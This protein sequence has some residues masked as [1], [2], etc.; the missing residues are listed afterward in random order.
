[1]ASAG[2]SAQAGGSP[3]KLAKSA[4]GGCAQPEAA[5]IGAGKS[6]GSDAVDNCAQARSALD[7]ANAA[8]GHAFSV[9]AMKIPA[10]T[11]ALRAFKDNAAV[12]EYE[13]AVEAFEAASLDVLQHIRK[14]AGAH[15]V[16]LPYTVSTLTALLETTE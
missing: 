12:K 16:A 11:M 5:G 15:K 2:D 7:A 14:C 13:A 10:Y 1:M 9:V 3:G 8:Q 4:G 6:N